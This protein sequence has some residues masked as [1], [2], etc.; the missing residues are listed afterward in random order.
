MPTGNHAIHTQGATT[1]EAVKALLKQLA[2]KGL[3]TLVAY[4]GTEAG[5]QEEVE[6]ASFLRTLDQKQYDVSYWSPINQIHNP[7]TLYIVKGR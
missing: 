7:P 1:I 4:P 3:I 6:L 5:A 2:P